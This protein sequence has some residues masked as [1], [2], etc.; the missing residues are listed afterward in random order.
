MKIIKFEDLEL[1]IDDSNTLSTNEVAL[2]YE[3]S[4]STIREH[5]KQHSDELLKNIHYIEVWD[6]KFKRY[7]TR[8]TL[9]GVHMLG[10]FIKSE[11]AKEFRK[12]TAKLL[13]EIKK[14]NVQVSATPPANCPATDNMSTRIAGYKGQLALKNKKIQELQFKLAIYQDEIKSLKEDKKRAVRSAKFFDAL[15]EEEKAK[16]QKY[17]LLEHNLLD[18]AGSLTR[19]NIE[20]QDFALQLELIARDLKERAKTA[21]YFLNH[22][23]KYYPKA[24]NIVDGVRGKYKKMF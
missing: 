9:E 4:S 7:I 22:I 14:G 6:D 11:R 24:K 1:H 3:V 19:Q 17:L 8:W 23:V 10:F 13:T 15:Y 21:Q 18:L 20:L 12:F 2:G 5:K 16:N